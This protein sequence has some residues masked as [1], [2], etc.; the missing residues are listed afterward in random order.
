MSTRTYPSGY[1]VPRFNV[2]L[3]SCMDLRLLDNIV[4]FMDH[5]NLTNRYD[6]FIMAGSSI[7]ALFADAQPGDELMNIPKYYSWKEGLLNHVDLAIEL[8]DIKDIYIL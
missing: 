6:Q 7:G 5:D 1:R 4:H 8:H 2:L 3:I